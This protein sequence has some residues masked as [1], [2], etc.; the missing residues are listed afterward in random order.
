MN[1]KNKRKSFHHHRVYFL[2]C[3]LA[4][5]F[6]SSSLVYPVKGERI[7]LNRKSILFDINIFI[8]KYVWQTNK[9]TNKLSIHNLYALEM[10]F[11]MIF[12]SFFLHALFL[13]TV[14]I[15]RNTHG[16]YFTWN[17]V[18]NMKRKINDATAGKSFAKHNLL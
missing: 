18:L 17:L 10:N 1:K 9:K 14:M 2:R 3:C 6:S 4:F 15:L 5:F 16:R 13:G 8:L 12:S 7:Y 11:F